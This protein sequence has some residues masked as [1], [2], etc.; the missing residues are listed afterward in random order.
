MVETASTLPVTARLRQPSS[1]SRRNVPSLKSLIWV[2]YLLVIA[3]YGVGF[4]IWQAEPVP[5]DIQMQGV[6]LAAMCIFPAALW[7]YR[8]ARGVPMFELICVS[9]LTQY[10]TQLYW[11]QNGISTSRGFLVFPWSA[12][13]ATMNLVIMGIGAMIVAYYVVTIFHEQLNLPTINIPLDERRLRRYIP[14]ALIGGAMV[15][16]L[17]TGFGARLGDQSVASILKLFSNQALIGIVLL[18]YLLFEGRLSN[19]RP[20]SLLL[21]G[22][23]GLIAFLGLSTG[24]L[25]NAIV[26]IVLIFIVRWH[27]ARKISLAVLIAFTALFLIFNSV[28]ADFRSHSARG[29]PTTAVAERAGIWWDLAVNRLGTVVSGDVVSNGTAVAHPAQTR[30]DLL[31][32][33][34]LVYTKTPLA[35]PYFNGSTYSYLFYTFIPRF[36][37]NNKPI[38]QTQSIQAVVDYGILTPNEKSTSVG[39]GQPAEA[40]ANWGSLGVFLVMALEGAALATVGSVFNG[41][42]SEGGRAVY[43]TIM[44]YF[45]NGIGTGT[46]ALF[47]SIIQNSIANSLVV[48][49]AAGKRVASWRTHAASTAFRRGPN[50]DAATRT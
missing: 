25:E 36:I 38:A 26:P 6:A 31:H 46:A 35:V 39:L 4:G 5:F 40:Y 47:G 14:V 20:W 27:A 32:Q 44:I 49:F 13:Q 41:P 11:N 17:Q 45:L 42:D 9:Y 10:G 34:E 3:A 28:K 2:G 29:V 30:L 23:T 16:L 7:Y 18:A 22:V 8:G 24:L 37:W 33:M 12:T 50:G 19:P 43:L 15:T 21:F 48:R 1:V